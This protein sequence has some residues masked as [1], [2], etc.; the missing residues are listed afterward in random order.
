MLFPLTWKNFLPKKILSSHERLLPPVNNTFHVIN[1]LHY[2][3]TLYRKPYNIVNFMFVY[4]QKMVWKWHNHITVIYLFIDLFLC[5]WTANVLLVI[6]KMGEYPTMCWFYECPKI[7]W[8]RREESS[9]FGTCSK[10]LGFLTFSAQS[11][12]Y[13][14]Y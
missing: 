9:I 8:A 4:L 7:H 6:S 1:F 12:K 5:S 13:M 2:S 10:L 11:Q 14:S 3:S